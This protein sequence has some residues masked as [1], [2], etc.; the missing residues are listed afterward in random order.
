LP[1][2]DAGEVACGTNL[3]L[4]LA[5]VVCDDACLFECRGQR[6]P[7]DSPSAGKRVPRATYRLQF[8]AGFT[9]RDA[10]AIVPYL[11]R[12]GVSHLYASP[13]FKANPGSM[14]GY[15]TI[16]YGALNP[17][18]GTEAE[19]AALV[20]TLQRHEMG[21][22]LDFV[23]NHMGIG[24]GRN[25]W[26]QNVLEFGSFS[27]YAPFFD[28][29]WEPLKP[30]LEGQVLLPVLGDQ[31]GVV[32]EN[33]E[34]KLGFAEGAF[35]LS[36]YGLPLPISPRTYPM[37][38]RR[39]LP[40]VEAEHEPD[41]LPL[42]EFQSLIAAFERLGDEEMDLADR[43][44][45]QFLA[46]RRLAQLAEDD[47]GV[48]RAIQRAVKALNGVE[49][50]PASFDALD[51]LITRQFYRLAFWRVAVDEINYRRFFA[52]NELAA[53]RQEVPEVFDDT[54]R[55]LL[56]FVAEGKV[57][58]I[59][60][61]HPDGL[62]DPAGYFQR[63]QRAVAEAG[64]SIYVVIEKIL[65]HGETLPP[66]WPVDG[67]VGYEFAQS[68][69]GLF[70]DAKNR[71]AFD[72]IYG[73][74]TGFS[75]RFNDLVYDKKKLIMR[76][77]LASEVNVLARA[78]D[79]LSEFRRR[80]RDFTHNSLRDAM[81]EVIAC[82]PIYRTYASCDP[83]CETEADRA[84]IEHA[85][86]DAIRRNPA[87]DTG[88]FNFIRDILLLS[89]AGNLSDEQRA[90][91]CRFVMKFQ[92]LSG[93]VMAKG[94]EDTAFYIYFRLTSLNEVGGDPAQ[95]GTDPR[96]FHRQNAARLADWPHAM[97][98]STTHDT[99]RSED[100]RARINALSEMPKVWRAALNRWARMNRKFKTK[101]E[102]ALA[103]DRNDEYLLYQTL[104]GAWPAGM[105]RPDEAFI[106]RIDAYLLKAIREAQVHSSWIQPND[107][108][109]GAASRFTHAILEAGNAPFLDDFAGIQER[110]ALDGAVNG[111]AQQALKL[112]SP[113]V[114]D[115]YQGSELWELS[116]V[117]P[118]NR[119]PVDF[120]LRE[121][122]LDALPSDDRAALVEN[123][124]DGRIK[125]YVTERLLAFRKERPE[126]FA[127]GAYLPLNATGAKASHLVAFARQ[128]GDDEVIVIAPRLV[129]ALTGGGT[130]LPTG[131]VW[132]DTTLPLPNAVKGE[133]WR[134]LFTG[135]EFDLSESR[136]IDL[137]AALA[138]LPVAALA[139]VWE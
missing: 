55:L 112:T 1:D 76:V 99:K 13:I 65:E 43:D 125:L 127:E 73:R 98:N 129:D 42:L 102:G 108:Y 34:L 20:E 97:L 49:G 75:E 101:V 2:S 64:Q 23:P 48:R 12:L 123:W 56:R 82:F 80:T 96:E 131:E 38:L 21:L 17:E 14:H 31:Y 6:V 137:A 27:A 95:F 69:G 135:A 118:D 47:P 15:D 66:E 67:T 128:L 113:G 100:V 45:E 79:R 63:L 81:I 9:F 90:E 35:A 40:A 10:E 116:L 53:I 87:A 124:Q 62:W 120:R 33:K 93:P 7:T 119:R 3:A 18:I 136:A 110:V 105:E 74:F 26:W 91:Q 25:A 30:E 51:D 114:P 92:Q 121:R 85:V 28:I 22:V 132:G 54:H 70:V 103:P 41:A 117:D 59:R 29:D 16:D 86:N 32:L 71:K 58:G 104:L 39:A 60:I 122:L 106:A 88:V 19:F 133:R 37:I 109:D 8:H 5:G 11:A 138:V 52:I 50:K 139:R 72:E 94:L 126:L 46:K 115:L 77:A 130:T 68:A 24:K 57:D 107:A 44:R 4:K 89:P 84:A 36:Y 61:D 134:D 78:L 83:E 111:L